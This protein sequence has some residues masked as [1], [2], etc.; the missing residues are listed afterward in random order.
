MLFTNVSFTE[1]GLMSG[2]RSPCSKSGPALKDQTQT[3]RKENMNATHS[4][5]RSDLYLLAIVCYLVMNIASPV[6]D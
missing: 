2:F 1:N 5:R 4:S 3:Y 6:T